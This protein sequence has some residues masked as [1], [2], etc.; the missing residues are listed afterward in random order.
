MFSVLVF[1]SFFTFRLI[2]IVSRCAADVG[3]RYVETFCAFVRHV[4]RIK[5]FIGVS[6]VLRS[7]RLLEI[8]KFSTSIWDL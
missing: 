8:L 6:L 7:Y 3:F 2:L 5:E 1:H 4:V